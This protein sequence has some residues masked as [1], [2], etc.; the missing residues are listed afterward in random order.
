VFANTH[1]YVPAQQGFVDV[2]SE[3][4]I[5]QLSLDDGIA[6]QSPGKS[7]PKQK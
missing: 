5:Q 6:H 7:V 4:D 3:E 2:S 1:T